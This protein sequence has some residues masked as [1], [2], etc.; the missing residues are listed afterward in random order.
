[1]AD[2]TGK[3]AIVTGAASGIGRA[4]AEVLA[5]DG[6][7]VLI[8]DIN[9]EKAQEVA[10]QIVG[11]G[12][13]AAGFGVDVGEEEQVRAMVEAAVTKYG[14]L[15]IL[16]NN[17]ALTSADVISRDQKWTDFDPA[18]FER[19]MRVNV[20][21]YALGA[22]YA[23]PQMI[24]QGGGVVI[25]TSSVDAILSALVRPMYGASKSAINALTRSLATQYGRQ[26]I[27]AVGVSPGMI[28]T[29]GASEAVPPEII[30]ILNKHNLT[31]REGRPDDIAHLVSFL[32]SDKA[33]FLTGITVQVDGGLTAHFPT[34]ADD[35]AVAQV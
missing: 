16:H 23:V 20:G 31:A 1:M 30:A 18:L 24:S 26:G 3:V 22:K 27:R 25:N 5:A 19:V 2:L 11:R 15:D 13:A 6:A 9:A 4:T 32:A 12:Q 21:G 34:Y 33:G 35:L 10:D 14:R 17:A 28:I 29:E 8:A 7:S